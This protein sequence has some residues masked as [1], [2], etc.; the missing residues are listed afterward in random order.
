MSKTNNTAFSLLEKARLLESTPLKTNP[1]TED[2]FLVLTNARCRCLL[3]KEGYKLKLGTLRFANLFLYA[4][5]WVA[6]C[7]RVP[8][9]EIEEIE[10]R[11]SLILQQLKELQS[12]MDQLRKQ[13]QSSSSST[14]NL[15][16]NDNNCVTCPAKTTLHKPNFSENGIIRDVVINVNPKYPPYSLLG[17]SKIWNELINL[18][19]SSYVHSTVVNVPDD[20]MSYFASQKSDFTDNIPTL[21]VTL[22]WKNI[23]RDCEFIVSPINHCTV[24]GEVNILRFLHRQL[25]PDA[26]ILEETKLDEFLDCCY[27]LTHVNSQKEKL[28]ILRK[29]NAT[30][31]KSEW[32]FGDVITVCDLAA[33]SSIRNVE[34]LELTQKMS[35]W[36]KQCDQLIGVKAA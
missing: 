34:N 33:W 32:F 6:A 17:V 25:N 7:F 10:T 26:D 22:I 15:P 19:I 13:L 14:S 3:N 12:Q 30:L 11:Q 16:L 9:P 5:S 27:C 18:N 20:I 31:G 21:N 4:A 36:L 24:N 8:N 1:S 2:L 28:S 29:M 23:G 35:K